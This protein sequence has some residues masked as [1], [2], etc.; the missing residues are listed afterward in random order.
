MLGADGSPLVIFNAQFA[1]GTPRSMYLADVRARSIVRLHVP[2]AALG[3]TQKNWAPFWHDGALHMLFAADPLTVLRCAPSGACTCIFSAVAEADGGCAAALSARTMS[4]LRL[5]APLTAIGD[6]GVLFTFL[7][8]VVRG[9]DARAA[10][11]TLGYRSHAALLSTS[12]WGWLSVSGPLTVS[13]GARTCA[14]AHVA[15]AYPMGL[16]YPTTAL[17]LGSA[18]EGA[19]V[20]VHVN[21]AESTLQQVEW[22]QPLADRLG[23]LLGTACLERE[24][25]ATGAG[26]REP[27]P[28]VP[29]G[30]L[31]NSRGEPV[32]RCA[33]WATLTSLASAPGSDTD[34]AGMLSLSPL[35][36]LGTFR[37]HA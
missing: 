20:G 8:T 23:A 14:E 3:I 36:P 17:L 7:H 21:D 19:L 33:R 35:A 4:R 30:A 12:P 27:A 22:E 31:R 1:R 5:G 2:G 18:G 10:G 34:G 15:E 6:S 37:G 25:A 16:V 32:P 13:G 29:A 11:D 26:A 9:A 24:V 28:A